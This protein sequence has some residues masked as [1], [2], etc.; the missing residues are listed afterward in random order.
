MRIGMI[1]FETKKLRKAGEI[2]PKIIV[3]VKDWV[4]LSFKIRI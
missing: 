1:K 4:T 3:L 2:I